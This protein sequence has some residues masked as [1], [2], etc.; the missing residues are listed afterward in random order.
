MLIE[1]IFSCTDLHGTDAEGIRHR[2]NER[3]RKNDDEDLLSSA[4]VGLLLG[5]GSFLLDVIDLHDL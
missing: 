1:Y 3:K 2:K 4:Q 5:V